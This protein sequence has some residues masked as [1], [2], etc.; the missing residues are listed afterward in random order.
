MACAAPQAP[1]ASPRPAWPDTLT[2][3]AAVSV[4][5]AKSPPPS[6][7]KAAPAKNSTGD[8]SR[9][10]TITAVGKAL[11]VELKALA[12]KKPEALR[13]ERREKYLAMGA[14]GLAA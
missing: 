12:K 3:I 5:T 2:A 8:C 11:E 13:K 4:D 7:I 14:K 1:S 10:D 6:P 9:A